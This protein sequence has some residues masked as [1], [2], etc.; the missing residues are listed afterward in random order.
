MFTHKR[1]FKRSEGVVKTVL[2]NGEPAWQNGQA[3]E[4]L[5]TQRMGRALRA[6]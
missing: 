6:A 5:G 4:A 2:I 3:T 1:R